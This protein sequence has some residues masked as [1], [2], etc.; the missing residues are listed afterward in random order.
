MQEQSGCLLIYYRRWEALRW[1]L[2]GRTQHTS[3]FQRSNLPDLQNINQNRD[4]G[5]NQLQG[6]VPSCTC[7]QG[8]LLP[9]P[10]FAFAHP[11]PWRQAFTMD[12][13]NTRSNQANLLVLE[14][15]LPS[16][17]PS[18]ECF[19]FWNREWCWFM[20][21]MNAA[22]GWARLRA[23]VRENL[24]EKTTLGQVITR[25]REWWILAMVNIGNGNLD[26]ADYSHTGN[27]TKY[28]HEH[29]TKYK[30]EIWNLF[31]ELILKTMCATYTHLNTLLVPS[32]SY[33]LTM[34]TANG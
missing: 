29:A 19:N 8:T 12:A 17:L 31:L 4:D 33:L 2:H 20:K 7:T 11:F 3:A 16:R 5:P 30:G 25:A 15:N 28:H 13:I 18:Q 23:P 1:L 21:N 27:K 14:A 26:F 34:S 10:A 9:L 24:E 22:L 32:G 6:F